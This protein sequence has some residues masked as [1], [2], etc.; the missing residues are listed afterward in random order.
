MP[1]SATAEQIVRWSRSA[2]DAA[3]VRFLLSAEAPAVDGGP[4]PQLLR[5]TVDRHL[6]PVLHRVIAG[7]HLDAADLDALTAPDPLT[8]PFTVDTPTG[9]VPGTVAERIDV[10]RRAY[11]PFA[12]W[13]RGYFAG[14]GDDPVPLADLWRLYLP[15]ACWIAAEKR[16]RRPDG[17]FVMGFNGSPG[18]G[19]TVLSTAL[20]VLLDVLLDPETEGRAVARSGD[21]WYLSRAEREPLRALGYDPGIPG[22]TNRSGPGTHDL[23]WL[24]RNLAELADSSRAGSVIRMGNFDKKA[25]DQP[26]GPDRYFEVRGRVGVFLFDLWFAGAETD[27]D[28]A[29]VPDGLRRRVAEQLRRWRPV[30]DRMDALW[31]FEWPSFAQMVS[32]REAQEVLVARRRGARGMSPEQIRAFMTYMIE[33]TWDWRTTSPVPPDHAVTFHAKRAA[34]HRIIAVQRGGRAW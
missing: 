24:R 28:P 27:V 14:H 18:S 7:A 33:R 13:W 34:N 23:A 22:V 4:E 8:E 3:A 16:R 32:D 30:F 29:L 6:T 17:L 31:S 15:L 10:L 11:G 12:D 19:K 5:S 26:T 9:V 1:G 21:D 25:D 20:A 2:P